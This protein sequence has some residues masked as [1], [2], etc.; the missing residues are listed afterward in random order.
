MDDARHGGEPLDVAAA[1]ADGAAAGVGVVDE[2]LRD[3][4]HRL[5]PA[6][7][8]WGKAGAML[9]WYM[10]HPSAPEKSIP[11]SDA[12]S[13][14]SGPMCSFAAGYRSR[15]CTQNRPRGTVWSA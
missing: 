14:A 4:G 15:W 1:D 11:I 8:V 5:E 10:L 9:P 7:R 12:S 2:A 3:E 13:E 6:V